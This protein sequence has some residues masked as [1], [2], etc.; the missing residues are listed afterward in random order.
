MALVGI[1]GFMPS[2][3]NAEGGHG[4]DHQKAGGPQGGRLLENTD[5]RAEFYVEK[6]NTVTITFYND[7]LKP[8][9]AADQ[10]V[11]VIAET[12]GSKTQLD[13]EK[14]GDVL[15]SKEG[16]PENDDLKLVVSFR[17]NPDSKPVNFRFPLE[18]DICGECKRAEY[19]CIC[20]H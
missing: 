1:L 16:L 19:A 6:D 10:S 14:K 3:L 17:Q 2:I 4:H 15:V 11:T 5:P 20:E 7:A 12:M 9:P 18:K 8:V 13:F